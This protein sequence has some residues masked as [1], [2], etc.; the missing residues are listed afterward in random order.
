MPRRHA[1]IT[2]STPPDGSEIPGSPT[3]PAHTT[4]TNVIATCT[5]VPIAVET[6]T[7]V[8]AVALSMPCLTR[9]RRFNA[10]PPTL[11]GVTRLVNDEASWARNVVPNGTPWCTDPAKRHGR[12]DVGERTG[13]EGEGGPA[14]VALEGGRPVDPAGE[15]GEQCPHGDAERNEDGDALPG[16]ALELGELRSTCPR[17]RPHAFSEVLEVGLREGRSRVAAVAASGCSHGMHSATASAPS[18]ATAEATA[19]SGPTSEAVETRNSATS[20]SSAS[21]EASTSAAPKSITQTSSPTDIR[22]AARRSWWAIPARCRIWICDHAGPE[23][24]ITEVADFCQGLAVDRLE[25][26]VDAAAFADVPDREDGGGQHSGGPG[27]LCDEGLVLGVL[28]DGSGGGG[29]G[30]VL[31]AKG[32]P[33]PEQLRGS[34]L[35]DRLDLDEHKVAA[36]PQSSGARRH[37]R[38]HVGRLAERLKDHAVTLRQLQQRGDLVGG[39]VG[40]EVEAQ[41]DGAEPHARVFGH[42]QGPSKIQIALG[43]DGRVAELDANRR[44]DRAQGHA[45]AGNE[46]LEQHVARAGQRAVAACRR[47]QSRR[48]QRASCLDLAGDTL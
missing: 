43:G 13:H 28:P 38:A 5:T 39:G 34:Q 6:A 4:I 12:A 8:A 45:G 2:N 42:A 33:Q 11:A 20:R 27:A 30:R 44:G 10:M 32:L 19:R 31:Q 9:N 23:R 37:R 16:D 48:D 26:G 3:F 41:A 22:L 46:R 40:H 18:T 29:V 15:L 35:V 36:G 14:G 21:L 7:P 1:P 47:V 25:R 24:G 17:G